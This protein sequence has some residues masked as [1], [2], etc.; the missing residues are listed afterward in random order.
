MGRE[1]RMTVKQI[2]DYYG[3]SNPAQG[4]QARAALK[5]LGAES[6]TPLLQLFTQDSSASTRTFGE[7]YKVPKVPALVA[8]IAIFIWICF[9]PWNS[10]QGIVVCVVAALMIQTI[11]GLRESPPSEFPLHSENKQ[12]KYRLRQ[13][14]LILD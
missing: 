11:L 10:Y 3:S 2:I 13:I 1:S 4:E 6:V 14:E 5:R 9:G 12:A 7:A 8:L